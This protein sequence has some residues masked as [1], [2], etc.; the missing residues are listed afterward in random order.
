MGATIGLVS[1]I[2]NHH[3]SG[4]IL[5]LL[6]TQYT[7]QCGFMGALCGISGFTKLQLLNYISP[8]D[9]S[10][11]NMPF[12]E[13]LLKYLHQDG[14]AILQKIPFE[15]NWRVI[16]SELL[17]LGKPDFLESTGSALFNEEE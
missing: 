2:T 10:Y 8:L 17:A 15:E 9:I 6:G 3:F 13:P 7:F 14:I 4:I 12:T 11:S 5:M 1:T 16:N